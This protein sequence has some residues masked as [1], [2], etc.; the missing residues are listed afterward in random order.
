ME[1]YFDDSLLE[2]FAETF[3]GYGDYNGYYWLI[4]MEEG[5]GD[6][7]DN[8]EKRLSAWNKRGRSELED[9]AEFHRAIDLGEFFD[10]KPKRQPTWDKLTRILLSAEGL[11]STEDQDE[12]RKQI[13]EYRQTSLGKILGERIV[14]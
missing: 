13:R 2:H 3:Y 4:G 12:Q 10:E 5:G 11:L 1:N 7:F 6:S 9:V 14:S 8:V